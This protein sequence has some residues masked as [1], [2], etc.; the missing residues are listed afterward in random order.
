MFPKTCSTSVWHGM[1]SRFP[2]LHLFLD[3]D[4]LVEVILGIITIISDYYYYPTDSYDYFK[5]QL[6]QLTEDLCEI[7]K[8]DVYEIIID[9]TETHSHHAYHGDEKIRIRGAIHIP[10]HWS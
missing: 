5:Q 9:L 7:F 8:I 4:V 3:V 1:F 6:L 2:C 10:F